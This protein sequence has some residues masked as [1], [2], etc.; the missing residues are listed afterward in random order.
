MHTMGD[1][2]DLIIRM[3]FLQ[4]RSVTLIMRLQHLFQHIL[5]VLVIA[6]MQYD[7]NC[8]QYTFR[9]YSVEEGVAQSQVY[10]LLQ[11]S[12]G[13]LWLGT[14]GGGISRF[15]GS[16]FKTYTT[17][18]GLCNNY[19]WRIKE[20]EQHNLWIATNNGLSK[21]NG[22]R[23]EN[24]FPEGNQK[25]VSVQDFWI[26][27]SKDIWLATQNGIYTL[28]N[29]KCTNLHDKLNI[30][31]QAYYTICKVGNEYW[32]GNGEGL[33][34][35]TSS[36]IKHDEIIFGDKKMAVNVIRCDAVNNV[37]I[38]TYGDGVH[39]YKNK[40]LI[41]YAENTLLDHQTI[42]DIYFDKNQNVWFA[43]L[44][45][46]ACQCNLLSNSLNWIT[47]NEGLSNN[48]IRCIVQDRSGNYWLGTS[49]GGV[50][51]YFGKQFVHFDTHAGLG[52]NFIYSIYKDSRN[53]LWIG[54]STNGLTVLDSARFKIYNTVSGFANVKVKAIIEDNHGNL[55]FGTDGN[56]V[57]VLSDSVFT[58]LPQF[59]GMY[60]RGFDKDKQGSIW[61]ATAGNGL[62]NIVP[63]GED[64]KNN[65]VVHYTV[66]EGLLNDRLTSLHIDQQSRIWYGTELNGVGIF[67]PE[68]NTTESL[69]L[70]NGLP[71][72]AI[73]SLC[74]DRQ[75]NLWIG[76]A[77]DGIA[78]YAMYRN[79]FVKK[80]ID[81]NAQLKS[82]NIYLL[83]VD[84][85]N[86]LFAG[87]ETG[88][89]YLELDSN[90]RVIK[91]KHY[92]K[93]EGFLGI[94]T[95]QNAVYAEP[96]GTV[97]F[98]TINGLSKYNPGSKIKNQHEPVTTIN[99]VRLFF[100]SLDTQLYKQC[101]SDWNC[102]SHLELPYNKNHLS[103]DFTGIN[104]SN[105]DAVLFQW[106]LEGSDES[107]SPPTSQRT[108]T[109]SNIPPGDY[110]FK[111]RACNEDGIW[112]KHPATFS[113]T[114]RTPL[115]KKWWFM[116]LCGM[117]FLSL[118]YFLY[119]KRIAS[120]KQKAKTQ[121]AQLQ[122][123]MELS[124]LEHKALRLQMNP[125]FLF[126]AL[127]SIQS[128]I[129]TNNEQEAR[130]YLA[131]FSSLMRQILDNSR[132]SVIAL[133]QEIDTLENYL[134]IEKF[135]NGNRF[136][137]EIEIAENIE[138]DYVKIPPMLLQPFVENSIKHGLRYL[139]ERQG[140]IHVAFTETEHFIECTVTDNGIGRKQADAMNKQGKESYHTSTALLVI[141]ERLDLLNG[142][143]AVKPIDIIDLYDEQQ[144]PIGTKVI[145]QI[146]IT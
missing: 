13:Y 76:T 38:G 136:E 20:D 85:S 69:T 39:L 16:S 96:D 135:C 37:W 82:N 58:S 88:L 98:G 12:R 126:N 41:K 107:W 21:F 23:F 84:A 111:V 22:I 127:N 120:I 50:C 143:T 95:C 89:D 7:V 72:N 129:G 27:N 105:P 51:N 103:F 59:N 3:H 19:V 146:P 6:F 48:H 114:I 113:F 118:L 31:K 121:Q 11:D 91:T 87:S 40:T 106:K 86:N 55:Y 54:T 14:R 52:G 56:G 101:I 30:K 119:R 60:V 36:T 70:K 142:N 138:T 128:L 139:K 62:Y 77:G 49:G 131:K 47:E 109:Y 75:G 53:R 124:E 115:W 117:V 99:N 110:T 64:G 10:T 145:I 141:Q 78:C 4:V 79:D 33:S 108:V 73:R 42:L 116:T 46:G 24:F 137:Y 65:I 34:R 66:S 71:S 92:S 26:E 25:A 93:G 83:C 104:L 1:S 130:Y 57:Y 122:L 123:K 15:D 32:C 140:Y 90:R 17:K 43:T 81:Y 67:T 94:E 112:N 134:L 97:W 45:N 61:M 102:I 133:Q 68:K 132:A 125:H 144:N 100:T 29:K 5:I 35:V 18:D 2:G 9:N 63:S 44:M 8:Q 80:N 74:E 28:A